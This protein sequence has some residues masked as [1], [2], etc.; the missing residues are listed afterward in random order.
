MCFN[1]TSPTACQMVMLEVTLPSDPGGLS[2]LTHL[3]V[4]LFNLWVLVLLVIIVQYK[5]Q[6]FHQS[7][8]L[9]GACPLSLSPPLSL[10][11]PCYGLC[12]QYSRRNFWKEANFGFRSFLL[13]THWPLKTRFCLS[14]GFLSQHC[15]IPMV[16]LMDFKLASQSNAQGFHKHINLK[17]KTVRC[18][19]YPYD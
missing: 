17:R 7:S 13:N 9:Y 5:E 19:Q 16:M 15:A 18:K 10:A 1:W 4:C 14:F 2:F 11:L 3:F 8:I 6:V 12:Q